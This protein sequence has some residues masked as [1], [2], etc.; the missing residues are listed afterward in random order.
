MRRMPNGKRC[1]KRMLTSLCRFVLV[2]STMVAYTHEHLVNRHDLSLQSCGTTIDTMNS[3]GT[4]IF[5]VR[6]RCNCGQPFSMWR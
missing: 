6:C 3:A 2:E 4:R 5:K 1:L